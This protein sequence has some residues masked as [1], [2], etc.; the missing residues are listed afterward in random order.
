MIGVFRKVTGG[1]AT[2]GRSFSAILYKNTVIDYSDLSELAG[3]P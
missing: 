3:I 2:P 1:E